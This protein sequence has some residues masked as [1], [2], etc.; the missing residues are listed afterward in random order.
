VHGRRRCRGQREMRY[1]DRG[2]AQGQME[3]RQR[4]LDSKEEMIGTD[5]KHRATMTISHVLEGLGCSARPMAHSEEA[6]EKVR[7]AP[8]GPSEYHNRASS[9]TRVPISSRRE[10]KSCHIACRYLGH[11]LSKHGRQPLPQ[12]PWQQPEEVAGRGPGTSSQHQPTPVQSH[13]IPAFS[14]P[15]SY[16]VPL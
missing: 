13:S 11:Q 5:V 15:A 10:Q 6:F 9:M 3:E 12:P 14:S 8:F 2:K 7:F 1:K 16:C 4:L